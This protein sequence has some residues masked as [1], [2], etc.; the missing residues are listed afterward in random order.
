MRGIWRAKPALLSDPLFFWASRPAGQ[1]TGYSL[2]PMWARMSPRNSIGFHLLEGL[3]AWGPLI[4]LGPRTKK[5]ARQQ[6]AT[7]SLLSSLFPLP[8]LSCPIVCSLQWSGC[9]GAP[10]AWLKQRTY[11]SPSRAK[12]CLA[13]TSGL[14]ESN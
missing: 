4:S 3:V 7:N 10:S 8:S 14:H 2:R 13:D 9:V 5:D 6:M 1:S 12:R 11:A